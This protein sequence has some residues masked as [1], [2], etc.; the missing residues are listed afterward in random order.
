MLGCASGTVDTAQIAK[1]TLLLRQP[2][3]WPPD[4]PISLRT[5]AAGSELDR[6]RRES[7]FSHD[8]LSHLAYYKQR[9]DLEELAYVTSEVTAVVQQTTPHPW[10]P[11]T[12]AT[13]VDTRSLPRN[14][15]TRLFAGNTSR[16]ERQVALYAGQ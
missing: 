10:G 11:L 7:V 8:T 2:L 15:S 9:S 13:A 5:T 14:G 12:P 3:T 1:S 16:V 4:L 6:E